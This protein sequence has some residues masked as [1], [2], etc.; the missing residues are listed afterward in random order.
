MKTYKVHKVH[1]LHKSTNKHEC[2]YKRELNKIE[3][4]MDC[5]ILSNNKTHRYLYNNK[6][7]QQLW[8]GTPPPPP[9]P[10]PPHPLPLFLYNKCSCPYVSDALVNHV[11]FLKKYRQESFKQSFP[12][13]RRYILPLPPLSHSTYISVHPPAPSS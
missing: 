2:T 4:H 11:I 13:Y 12:G 10:P 5:N 6:S 1:M 3:L 7:A 8:S 9:P